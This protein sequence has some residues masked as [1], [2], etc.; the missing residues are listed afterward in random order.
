M[1]I[2]CLCPT[3]DRR[4]YIPLAILSFTRQDWP[5]KE[6][7]ILDDGTDP[8]NDLIPSGHNILYARHAGKPASLPN[9][10]NQLASAAHGEIFCN[11]DDDDWSSPDRLTHQLT[12]L[13]TTHKAMTGFNSLFYWDVTTRKAHHW[14]WNRPSPYACGSSQMRTRQWLLAHPEKDTT[15][16]N[17]L[18]ASIE[19]RDLAQLHSE[20]G[21]PFLVARYHPHSHWRFPLASCRFPE[22]TPQHLPTL[23][24][25]DIAY[26]PLDSEKTAA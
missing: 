17:D 7:L 3:K 11:W 15:Q 21:E 25:T 13:L 8:I 5:E 14:V 26:T 12:Q 19:A 2:S 23:F 10:L 24:L 4:P 16:P 1:L 9:K 18:L 22:V 6:L 20:P